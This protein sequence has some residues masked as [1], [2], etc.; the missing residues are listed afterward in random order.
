MELKQILKSINIDIDVE[1]ISL[2]EVHTKEVSFYVRNE[3]IEGVNSKEDLGLMVEVMVDGQLGYTA[4]NS[5]QLS[6]IKAAA[7]RARTLAINAKKH[8][9]HPFSLKERPIVVGEY[10]S[11]SE[12]SFNQHT[13]KNYQDLLVDLTKA[14]KISDKIVDRVSYFSLIEMNTHMISNIG[15]DINQN[16]VRGSLG[17]TCTASDGK[18]SQRRT[19]GHDNNSQWGLDHL[20]R[21]KFINEATR[22]AHEAIELLESEDCPNTR[23]RRPAP[24]VDH[25][26]K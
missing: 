15:S 9:L 7:L 5:F 18:D 1:Y 10:K 6:D 17:L 4:I 12:Y 16:I 2:R 21:E 23:A 11:P 22:I 19:F 14:M 3:T 25:L 24:S 13:L 26:G 20:T 8:G